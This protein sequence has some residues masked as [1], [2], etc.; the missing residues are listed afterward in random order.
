[1]YNPYLPYQPYYPQQQSTGVL[2]VGSE[3]EA[4]NYP[5]APNN[6]VALWD[7]TKPAVYLKQADAS[8]KPTMKSYTLVE[9]TEST[10]I[11]QDSQEGNNT[12][13]ALKSD[14]EPILTAIAGLKKDIKA[15]KRGLEETDDDE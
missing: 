4:Q 8:G 5:V 9:R 6:A 2:W 12:T 11:T 7:S 13:F 3:Y 1:M 15:I 10:H 14:I